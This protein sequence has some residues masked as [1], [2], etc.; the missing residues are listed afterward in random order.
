M[1]I[2]ELSLRLH[3]VGAASS[4]A[5]HCEVAAAPGFSSQRTDHGG[6]EVSCRCEAAELHLGFGCTGL[7]VTGVTSKPTG[8]KPQ[9]ERRAVLHR[10][11][12]GRV[13][14]TTFDSLFLSFFVVLSLYLSISSLAISVTCFS[15]SLARSLSLS[16][17]F[18]SKCK[19][20]LNVV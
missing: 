16:L 10:A 15:P 11:V 4:F 12:L 9:A 17:S 14:A 19:S 1:V 6:L 8:S 18:A 5:E 7:G 3:G 2:F 20:L 13:A